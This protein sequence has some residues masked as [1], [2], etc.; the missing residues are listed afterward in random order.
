MILGEIILGANVLGQ[1]STGSVE[2]YLGVEQVTVTTYPVTGE[3]AGVYSGQP[4]GLAT[5][6][7]V[8]QTLTGASTDYF[9]AAPAEVNFYAQTYT[10]SVNTNTYFNAS[11]AQVNFYAA[12]HTVSQYSNTYLN[13][14]P[15]QVNFYAQNAD[16]YTTDNKTVSPLPAQVFFDSLAH[17]FAVSVPTLFTAEPAELNA[18][19]YAHS[20]MI[21]IKTEITFRPAEVI[22]DA[23]IS[24]SSAVTIGNPK[25]IFDL[26]YTVKNFDYYI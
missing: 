20:I 1:S 4:A 13:A 19:G 12:S 6:S 14:A 24:K 7:G 8:G 16:R 3:S 26:K 5:V 15:A 22:F 18:G 25:Y 21:P 23:T 11:P 10:N 17:A 9:N 2:T